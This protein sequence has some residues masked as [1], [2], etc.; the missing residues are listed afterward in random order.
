MT[1]AKKQGCDQLIQVAA[2]GQHEGCHCGPD[3]CLFVH[4]PLPGSIRLIV[5]VSSETLVRCPPGVVALSPRKGFSG[6]VFSRLLSVMGAVLVTRR[7][8]R[9]SRRQRRQ[10]WPWNSYLTASRR[11]RNTAQPELQKSRPTRWWP[12]TQLWPQ[13]WTYLMASNLPSGLAVPPA[14]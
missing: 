12:C 3:K 9:D 6:V 13:T 8:S 11:S 14:L 5:G 4:I 2:S 10:H 1:G 7:R